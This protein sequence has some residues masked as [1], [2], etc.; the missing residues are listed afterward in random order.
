MKTFMVSSNT[1]KLIKIR[2][3]SIFKLH[4]NCKVYDQNFYGG[5]EV[6]DREGSSSERCLKWGGG[7]QRILTKTS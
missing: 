1:Q 4:A 7:H 6:V 3:A 2:G 5:K